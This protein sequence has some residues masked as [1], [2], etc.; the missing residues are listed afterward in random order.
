MP[1]S[2]LVTVG[3]WAA[4]RAWGKHAIAGGSGAGSEAESLVDEA[5]R[6]VVVD[7]EWDTVLSMRWREQSGGRE[8]ESRSS[9]KIL[10]HLGAGAQRERQNG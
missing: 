3:T 10:G 1:D 5:E 9:D 2:C 7:W 6:A 8:R 4:G